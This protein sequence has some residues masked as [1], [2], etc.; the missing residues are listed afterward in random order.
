MIVHIT[1]REAWRSALAAGEYQAASLKT[2]GFIHCSEPEQVL[3]V[4]NAF[5]RQVPDQVLLWID[6]AQVQARL[7]WEAPAN[8]EHGAGERFPHI[9]GGLNLEAVFS[10]V[11]F[12]PD[13]D[14][15]FRHLPSP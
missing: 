10:V 12:L 11:E 13:A 9:Y 6:P 4:A 8:S 2:E 1:T 5:Y 3:A 7:V 15:V 14:G